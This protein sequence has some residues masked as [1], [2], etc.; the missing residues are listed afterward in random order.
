MNNDNDEEYA[1]DSEEHIVSKSE[2]KRQMHALQAMGST[3]INLSDDLLATMPLTDELE[4]AIADAKRI[5]SNE[6]LRRQKQYIGKLMRKA[7]HQA[8]GDA[9]K[10]IDEKQNRLA[11]AFQ[12]MEQWRDDLINGTDSDTAQFIEKFP[13]VNR[14]E[15]RTLIRNARLEKERNKPPANARKLFKLIRELMALAN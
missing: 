13:G 3:L 10:Q 14:Q 8:I 15:L 1:K 4:H 11:R 9:L 12:T 6:G 7:D 5:K 2:V